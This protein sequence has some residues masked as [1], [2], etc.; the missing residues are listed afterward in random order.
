MN[1]LSAQLKSHKEITNS[2]IKDLND[3]TDQM[4]NDFKEYSDKQDEALEEKLSNKF[5]KAIQSLNHDLEML[6]AEVE[7]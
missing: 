2:E 5:D 7:G 1:Q 6:R 4:K 3:K